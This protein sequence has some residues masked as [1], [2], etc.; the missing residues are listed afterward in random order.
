MEIILS[1][2]NPSKAHQIKAIFEDTGIV[3]L[4]LDDAKIEGEGVEDGITL[5]ENAEKKARFAQERAATPVWTMADDTGLF[6]TALDGAPGIYAARWAGEDATTEEIM[7]YC[8]KK[9][10]GAADRSATFKTVVAVLSPTGEKYFF[11]GVAEGRILESPR[12]PNQPKM[13]YSALFVPTGQRPSWAEMS[14]EEENAISH[15]GKA[16][17]Q[18]RDFLRSVSKDSV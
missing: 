2:R 10:Q 16:F 5:E 4:S 6:I 13:P 18:V 11:T 8:L 3:V 1:T 17:R 12:V 14:V 15:R 9:L 7:Q